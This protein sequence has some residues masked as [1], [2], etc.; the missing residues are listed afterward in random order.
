M[1]DEESIRTM[2][3]SQRK[4]RTKVVQIETGNQKDPGEKKKKRRIL[5]E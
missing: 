2:K 3:L 1:K 4:I 5:G